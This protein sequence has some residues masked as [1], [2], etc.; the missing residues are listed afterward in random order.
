MQ[1]HQ[2]IQNLPRFRNA[3]ITIGTFDGV[4]QGHRQIIDALMQ[5]A[6]DVGG[7]SVLITFNPH[8]RKIVSNAPLQLIN[9]LDEK[10]ELLEKTGVDHLVVVPFTKDF[11]AQSADDYIEY[12]LI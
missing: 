4:H 6:K 7:E 3:V 9:T 8:P 2:G 11:S 12:L 10:T 5:R 1:V